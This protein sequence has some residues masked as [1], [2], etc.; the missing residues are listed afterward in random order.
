[1][2]LAAIALAAA[3]ALAAQ[4]KKLANAQLETRSAAAGLDSVVQSLLASQPQPAWVGWTAPAGRGRNFGCDGYWR[5]HEI[6]SAGGVVHLEPPAEVMVL[7]RVLGGEISRL[8]ALAPDCEMDAGGVPFRWLTGV[9]PDDSVAWLARIAR[10]RTHHSGDAVHAIGLHA[11]AAADAAL[12]SFVAADQPEAL[13]LRGIQ[14]IGSTRG[15]RGAAIA[16]KLLASDPSAR[17]RRAAVSS[18]RHLPDGQGIPLLIDLVKTGKDAEVR[19]QAM[20]SLGQ[21]RDPRAMAFLE[22]VLRGR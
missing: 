2:K 18:L 19:R 12:E 20:T 5:D 22:E 8:R 14:W 10:A 15:S 7:A 11:G 1:M 21:S 4:P 3:M 6:A 9:R 16:Q 13:R 17:V